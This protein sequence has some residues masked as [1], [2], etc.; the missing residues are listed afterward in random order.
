MAEEGGLEKKANAAPTGG[1]GSI[2]DS[3]GSSID[4]LVSSVKSIPGMIKEAAYYSYY[5]AKPAVAL[6]GI[7]YFSGVKT[8][9]HAATMAGGFIAGKLL[10][11][12]K[13]KENI[14]S[15]ETYKEISNEGTVGAV[16]GGF[17]S[18]IF[19]GVYQLAGAVSGI[20][21]K[22]AGILTKALSSLVSMPVF[23]TT[24]EYARRALIGDYKPKPWEIRKK[25]MLKT[26][27]ILGLPVMANFTFCP[28]QYN[29]PAAAAIN[30]AY[31]YIMAGPKEEKKEEKSPGNYK[32]PQEYAMN[33]AT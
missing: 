8:L 9:I 27:A 15:K 24:D 28:P 25:Q 14:I 29:I 21:G 32:L 33:K 31:G 20:Y 1:G 26:A 10:S 11:K 18:Y 2:F 30:T 6:A 3:I 5:T 7:Y 19:K 16:L 17:L 13:N 23:M 4:S 22:A 12:L